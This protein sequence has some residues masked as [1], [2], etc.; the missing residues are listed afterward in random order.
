MWQKEKKQFHQLFCHRRA[1]EPTETQ[2]SAEVLSCMAL[3][4]LEHTSNQMIFI[5]QKEKKKNVES[6]K[7]VIKNK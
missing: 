5:K 6:K 1:F 7:K 2:E 3:Q 4:D